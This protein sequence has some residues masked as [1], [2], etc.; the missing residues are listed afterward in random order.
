MLIAI[1]IALV[2]AVAMIAIPSDVW[3]LLWENC[4]DQR[5]RMRA[6]YVWQ[7]TKAVG[8]FFS[9]FLLAAVVLTTLIVGTILFMDQNVIKTGTATQVISQA[10]LDPGTF[11]NNLT[12]KPSSVADEV[13]KEIVASGVSKEVA[14]E[15]ALLLWNAVPIAIVAAFTCLMVAARLSSRGYSTAMDQLVVEATSRNRRKIAR[16][17]LQSTAQNDE[18]WR[19]SGKGNENS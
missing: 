7:E 14:K 2:I 16:H 12:R 15:S 8:S 1:C 5:G 9:V 17:Y 11:A 3:S 18:R 6:R 19:R 13:Q 4:L 10:H